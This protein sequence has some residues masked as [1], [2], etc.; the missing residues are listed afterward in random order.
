MKI[1]SQIHYTISL[2]LMLLMVEQVN[3]EDD[4][5]ASYLDTTIHNLID[6]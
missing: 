6:E 3:C 1:Y 2:E 4:A 5:R